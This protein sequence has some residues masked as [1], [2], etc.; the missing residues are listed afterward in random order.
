MPRVLEHLFEDGFHALAD[1]G[2]DIQLHVVLELMPFRGQVSPSSLNP[3]LTRRYIRERL[4]G[5]GGYS[6]RPV[7]SSSEP[8]MSP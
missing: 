2:F 5:A 8:A 6:A 7:L 3:Q 4:L 1:S